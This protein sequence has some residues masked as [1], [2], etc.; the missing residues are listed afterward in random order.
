MAR[1]LVVDDDHSAVRGMTKLLTD[2]GHEVAPFTSGADAV[3]ALSSEAFDAVVT[4]LEMPHVDGHE[5]VRATREHH[6]T[7][8]LVVATAN[9]DAANHDK[10]A[11]A[12]ACLIADKPIDY[13]EVT[14]GIR[15]CR[16]RGGRSPHHCHLRS[17]AGGVRLTPL[18][19]K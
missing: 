8:C 7:A 11:E 17:R 1:F 18:R 16:A 10:L 12:G 15:E 9:V 13:E 2:D 19:R 14:S 6:P 3:T 4:D 5:V